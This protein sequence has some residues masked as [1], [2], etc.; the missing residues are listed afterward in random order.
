MLLAG[1][2]MARGRFLRREQVRAPALVRTSV[3][4]VIADGVR[5]RGIHNV[6][7]PE[8]IL[9]GRSEHA[10]PA[11]LG[12]MGATVTT[13]G[14]RADR[15]GHGLRRLVQTGIQVKDPKRGV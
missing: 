8:P 4:V 13:R 12:V 6:E 2:S 15:T 14:P 3:R 7:Y 11:H 10:R 5:A 1:A 9:I